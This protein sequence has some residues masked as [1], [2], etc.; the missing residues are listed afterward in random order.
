I[1]RERRFARMANIADVAQ[2]ALLPLLPRRAAGVTVAASYQSAAADAVVG[3]DLYDCSLVG[4]HVRFLIGDVRG[5]GIAAVEQ[6]ARVIRAFRQA[7]A[8][9]QTPAAVVANVD[10]YVTPFLGDEDFATAL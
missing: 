10:D 3:G 8:L 4:G 5:K 9:E 1:L 7:A 2:R 6:A